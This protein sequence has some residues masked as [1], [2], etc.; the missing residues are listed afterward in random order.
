MSKTTDAIETLLSE[1]EAD[2]AEEDMQDCT[3]LT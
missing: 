1:L 2:V 3:F